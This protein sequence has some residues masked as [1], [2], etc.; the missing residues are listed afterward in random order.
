[1]TFTAIV[2]DPEGDPV[3]TGV[4]AFT[5][6]GIPVDGSPVVVD[7]SGSATFSTTALAPGTSTVMATYAQN[8]T[9]LGSTAPLNHVVRPIAEAN[10]PYAVAEGAGLTLDATGSTDGATFGWDLN[11]DDDFTDAAGAAPS[12]TWAQL[13]DL[14][15]DDG[16]S[17]HTVTVRVTFDGGTADSDA[18]LTVTN[19]APATVLTGSLDATVAVPFTIKVGA[20]DPSAAD[21]AA[22]F[23]YAVDWGDGSP[24]LSV[25]GPADPPVT[26]LY[27]SAGDYAASFTATDKD[28]GPGTDLGHHPG[29]GR[30]GRHSQSDGNDR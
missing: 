30:A 23:T 1:M 5:V 7:P 4:V 11:G 21:A 18:E 3:T 29:R 15:I 16:P 10:G 26:H 13:E 9:Y 19:T 25:D 28:G 20:A 12:L 14:G 2:T 6:D 17:S 8:D 27:T 22:L 24:V